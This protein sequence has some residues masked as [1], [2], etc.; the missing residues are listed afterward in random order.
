MQETSANELEAIVAH[1]IGHIKHNH[2]N[3]IL[4]LSLSTQLLLVG[5]IYYTLHKT[6]II[7]LT[8]FL[9]VERVGLHYSIA[10]LLQTI[11]SI[12]TSYIINKRY[13]KEADLFA[14]KA[15]KADGLIKFF[16]QLEN[17]NYKR[18]QQFTNTN[19]LLADNYKDFKTG[20]YITLKTRYYIAKAG[21]LFGKAYKWLY[22]NTFWGAHPSPQERIK[23]AKEYAS[24]QS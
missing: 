1:E 10:L 17:K 8:D 15:H 24:L 20:D 6:D 22:Y 9:P 19:N 14:C 3:K 18:E 4:A 13:E 16:N 11:N 23:A 5:S 21:H 2:V 12:I 7:G